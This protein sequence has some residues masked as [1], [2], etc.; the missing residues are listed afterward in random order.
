MRS[1]TLRSRGQLQVAALLLFGAGCATL[2]D[3]SAGHVGCR[4]DEIAISDD[5]GMGFGARTW[6]ATCRG[7]AYSCSAVSTGKDSSQVD[8]SPMRGTA[9]APAGRP[10]TAAAA[11]RR[12]AAAPA[13]SSTSAVERAFDEQHQVYVV[14]ATF[15]LSTGIELRL[16]SE[17]QRSLTRIAAAITG[18]SWKPALRTCEALQIVV[19]GQPAASEDDTATPA[20]DGRFHVESGFHFDHWKPLA[21][22]YST[23]EVH[24]C[25]DAWKL[26]NNQVTELK[27][28]LAFHTDLA[29]QVQRGELPPRSDPAAKAND[30]T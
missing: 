5:S 16:T 20:V 28:F 26:S 21:Q 30:G 17:P 13:G 27:K 8:C 22:G 2:Q 10:I 11:P 4:P 7:Q 1:R 3:A 24:A 14:R 18:R 15:G 6:T 19:N 25:K 23:F 29:A 9:S 12:A